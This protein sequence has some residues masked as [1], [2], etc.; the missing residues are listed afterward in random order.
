M[1]SVSHMEIQLVSEI[2]KSDSTGSNEVKL[3]LIIHD[4]YYLGPDQALFF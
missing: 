3:Q 2:W 1:Q 4:E